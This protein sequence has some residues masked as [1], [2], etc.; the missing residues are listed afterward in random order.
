[1]KHSSHLDP[2]L[3]V[4]IDPGSSKD[5]S[6]SDWQTVLAQARRES[7]L[8]YL[9]SIFTDRDILDQVP[10]KVR[11]QLTEAST[12]LKFNQ[13]KL[14]F[15]TDRVERALSDLTVT[16]LLLKG[17]A[18]LLADLPL[19]DRR[20][21]SDIDIM[22]PKLELDT[23]EAALCKAGWKRN[24]IT[25][26]DDRYYRDWMH[27]VPP[28]AHPDRNFAVDLHHTI[29]PLTSCHQ[30]N[31]EALFEAAVPLKNSRFK[32][33][34]PADMTLHCA[35]HLLNEEIIFGLRDLLDLH[36][37]LTYF[38]KDPAFWDN[39]VARTKLHKFER[40]LFY[41]LR[42]TE[43]LLG[44]EIP[45]AVQEQAK[46]GAPNAILRAVMDALFL[47]ALTPPRL[48]GAQPG[49][50]FAFWLLYLRS[51][52][53]KMPPLLLI[54]HLSIKAWRR[55]WPTRRRGVTSTEPG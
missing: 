1:L 9:H 4:F 6:S 20:L 50:A 22:V 51:H 14:R 27:E 33:L 21:V 29:V 55:W 30:P 53:L 31:T 2:L 3:R 35:V 19:A 41:L 16:L 23:V 36:E 24:E 40:T 48:S 43:R 8:L 42:Y 52:W 13:T 37:L 45:Q 44:T 46:K 34:C 47:R 12:A 10:E 49:R 38:G 28:M 18:Y 5:F 11:L 7:L 32:V 25:D 15:E 39:L 26:Y 54:K 17:G